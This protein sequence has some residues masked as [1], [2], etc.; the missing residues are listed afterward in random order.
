MRET[1]Q[2]AA[3]NGESQ[4]VVE[5]QQG[6]EGTSGE[7]EGGWGLGG[8][9]AGGSKAPSKGTLRFAI[10]ISMDG[11]VKDTEMLIALLCFAGRGGRGERGGRGGGR[12]GRG[13]RGGKEEGGVLKAVGTILGVI[14]TKEWDP[15]I[16]F[17]FARKDC[18]MYAGSLKQ[19]D[20]NTDEEKAAI[21]EVS[22][23][24]QPC[25]LQMFS[26]SLCKML[27][28][29]YWRNYDVIRLERWISGP[30]GHLKSGHSNRSLL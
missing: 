25:L 19:F 15:V 29:R 30:T 9:S 28:A 12:G 5:G 23:P 20:F 11:R 13:G 6:G 21:E 24:T 8:R 26:P 27:Y 16:F 2:V 10:C 7:V 22:T 3:P 14:K 4:E 18:E 17:S 1:F